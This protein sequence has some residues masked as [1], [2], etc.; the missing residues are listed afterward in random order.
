VYEVVCNGVINVVKALK[1]QGFQNQF[2]LLTTLGL[3]KISP[4]MTLLNIIKP[5]VVQA[6]QDKA[7]YLMQSGLLY[8]IIQA[9]AL[10]D[11]PVSNQPLVV[12]QGNIPMKINYQIGRQHLA[13]IL[14]A[15]INHPL[16]INKTFNVYGGQT[17]P[18]SEA[19]IDQQFQELS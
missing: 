14:V 12:K 13:Q 5:G 3:V 4:I 16:T 6:S 10:H 7:T 9:G 15:A 2:V 19:D 11:R 1:N 18:L 8:T 17:V